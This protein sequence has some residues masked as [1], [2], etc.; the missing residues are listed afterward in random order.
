MQDPTHTMEEAPP[1]S[2]PTGKELELVKHFQ[3]EHPEFTITEIRKA[4]RHCALE[5]AL[6]QHAD[7]LQRSVGETLDARFRSA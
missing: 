5:L 7:E 4:L 3:N 1:E 6:N 2:A